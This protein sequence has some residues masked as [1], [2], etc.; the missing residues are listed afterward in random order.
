MNIRVLL[1]YIP[2]DPLQRLSEELRGSNPY[3]TCMDVNGRKSAASDSA[4]DL[5]R[6]R[7]CRP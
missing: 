1:A 4:L 2:D 5:A 6:F 7:Q 3:T